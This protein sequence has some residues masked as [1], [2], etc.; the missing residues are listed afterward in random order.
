MR[1]FAKPHREVVAITNAMGPSGM[2]LSQ[3]LAQKDEQIA[4]LESRIQAHTLR[5][6]HI[7]TRLLST[8]DTLDAIQLTHAQEM[9]A[10][11]K[12]KKRAEEALKR[13]VGVVRSAE[14]ERDDM[15]DACKFRMIIA[16]PF[17]SPFYPPHPS[18]PLDFSLPL[19]PLRPNNINE[20]EAELLNYA[21]Q[22]IQSLR[23]GRDAE[24]KAHERTREMC[25]ARMCAL[26]AKLCR[27][28]AELES[29]APLEMTDDEA[30]QMLEMTAT[31]NRELE[32]EIRDLFRRLNEARSSASPPPRFPLS[33]AKQSSEKTTRHPPL[34]DTILPADGR[35]SRPG[36]RGNRT[37][38]PTG[39]ETIRP[40]SPGQLTIRPTSPGDITIRPQTGEGTSRPPPP[41]DAIL[42]DEIAVIS[43]A[44][45]ALSNPRPTPTDHEVI[46]NQR[47]T[48]ADERAPPEN[49]HLQHLRETQPIP[50]PRLSSKGNKTHLALITEDLDRQIE[51]LGETVEVFR[52]E[53]DE[54]WRVVE[55]EKRKKKEEQGGEEEEEAVWCIDAWAAW[56][57]WMGFRT[58]ICGGDV[59]S[60]WIEVVGSY[61]TW[62]GGWDTWKESAELPTERREEAGPS[63]ASDRIAALEKECT[64]LRRSEATLRPEVALANVKV[65]EEEP[66]GS[67]TRTIDRLAAL[68]EQCSRLR[69][70]EE[71]LRSEMAATKARENELLDEIYALRRQLSEAAFSEESLRP[72]SRTSPPR[73]QRDQQN[74]SL[75]NHPHLLEPDEGEVSMELATPLIPTSAIA[76][77]PRSRSHSRSPGI[78]GYND[79]DDVRSRSPR[80][81]DNANFEFDDPP[82]F[83]PPLS[84]P[85]GYLMQREG[86]DS[87]LTSGHSSTF[88]NMSLSVFP[89]PP[90]PSSATALPPFSSAVP[91]P[92]SLSRNT[93]RGREPASRQEEIGER[94]E[95]MVYR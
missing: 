27:R 6:T 58:G 66:R 12:G 7:H 76:A 87:P 9:S 22:I 52:R 75:L 34:D 49:N 40:T 3:K 32:V 4:S 94:G 85:I 21:S 43:T 8:L 88:P 90:N 41:D 92:L 78:M 39:D 64:R 44:V 54:L 95:D 79:D 68:E 33:Q 74:P 73:P 77:L 84:P 59:W 53:R 28:E 80:V 16:R 62:G 63:N 50:S 2:S 45:E 65:S 30:I 42:P 61:A 24:R 48:T 38:V 25:E 10:V 47:P 37:T 46:D 19:H 81:T 91:L 29:E 18:L 82:S 55:G 5:T 35:P 83:P 70:S 14:V 1:S 60:T 20:E 93:S 31:R 89:M 86:G 72:P 11:V 56:V 51:L 23:H 71:T 13:Y 26:E 17:Y 15:R 36:S 57:G 69:Q 67:T